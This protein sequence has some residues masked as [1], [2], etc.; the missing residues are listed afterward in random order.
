MSETNAL[1]VEKSAKEA[2]RFEIGKDSK[3][4]TTDIEA[5]GSSTVKSK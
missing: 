4:V 1:T 5:P 2:W 3:M